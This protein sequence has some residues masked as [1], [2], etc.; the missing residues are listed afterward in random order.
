MKPVTVCLHTLLAQVSSMPRTR[1]SSCQFNE[2][3]TTWQV[4]REELDCSLPIEVVY[5]G[6]Q[7]MTLE[8]L[9]RFEVR[10]TPPPQQSPRAAQKKWSPCW[11]NRMRVGTHAAHLKVLAR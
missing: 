7:E 11:A 6:S 1:C 3:F 5:S 4:L 9:S 10:Q 2:C 8:V